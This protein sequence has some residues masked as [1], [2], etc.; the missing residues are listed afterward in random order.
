MPIGWEMLLPLVLLGGVQLEGIAAE[1]LSVGV[2]AYV[3][4]A[5]T[6]ATAGEEGVGG[7][8]VR[9]R[10]LVPGAARSSAD[11]CRVW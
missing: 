5:A 2:A 8:E 7:L 4:A 6:E 1:R 11:P 3:D 9:G 10:D